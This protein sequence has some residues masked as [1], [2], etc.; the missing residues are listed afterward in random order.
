MKLLSARKKNASDGDF[1]IFPDR[2][3][4]RWVPVPWRWA[5][6]L[7]LGAVLTHCAHGHSEKGTSRPKGADVV[8]GGQAP[9][10]AHAPKPARRELEKLPPLNSR[11][12]VVEQGLSIAVPVEDQFALAEGRGPWSVLSAKASGEK[13]FISNRPARRSIT[14]DECEESARD[15]LSVLRHGLSPAH[16]RQVSSPEGYRGRLKVVLLE[17]GGG[18]VEVFSVALSRCMA[19]VYIAPESPGFA[20]RLAEF[21][22]EVVPSV[23]LAKRTIG[24]EPWAF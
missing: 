4:P 6:I 7:L 2:S 16:E 11:V 10:S 24:R 14:L 19:I 21:V 18:L 12:D 8:E 20:E 15:S 17:D 23:A 5:R 3:P 13:I 22:Q 9:E 1:V